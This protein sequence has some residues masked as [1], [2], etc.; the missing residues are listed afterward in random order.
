MKSFD[1]LCLCASVT[2]PPQGKLFRDPRTQDAIQA[3][4]A[5][6]GKAKG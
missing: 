5:N 4:Q 3:V 2:R 6:M 1:V